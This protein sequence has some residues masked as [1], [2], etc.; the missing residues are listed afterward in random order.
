MYGID[1]PSR[2]STTFCLPF[3]PLALQC[4]FC[5][6]LSLSLLSSPRNVLFFYPLDYFVL[7]SLVVFRFHRC[8]SVPSAPSVP[9]RCSRWAATTGGF[10]CWTRA[11]AAAASSTCS[12]RTPGRCKRWPSPRPTGLRCVPL[13][14]V[15]W[16]ANKRPHTLKNPQLSPC[17][18][19]A[20]GRSPAESFHWFS[21]HRGRC[22]RSQESSVPGKKG[23]TWC[24]F[25]ATCR[26]SR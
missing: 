21:W 14:P 7:V 6:R 22:C 24:V 16:V 10:D 9:G 18:P 20:T 26:D 23:G 15:P 1:I 3:L 11:C 17:L 13:S 5:V 4:V 19:L 2:I 25:T 12:R 8:F